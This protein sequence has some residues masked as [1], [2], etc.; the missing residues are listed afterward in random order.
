VGEWCRGVRGRPWRDGHAIPTAVGERHCSAQIRSGV[1][2][3]A[4]TWRHRAEPDPNG[5]GEAEEE[6]GERLASSGYVR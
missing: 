5:C 3:E 6:C 1:G 2:I 4:R